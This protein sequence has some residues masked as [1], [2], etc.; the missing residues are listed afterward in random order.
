MKF[1]LCW[2][3]WGTGSWGGWDGERGGGGGDVNLHAHVGWD[4]TYHSWRDNVW[5]RRQY[6][7]YHAADQS[8]IWPNTVS[9]IWAG[10]CYYCMR[11]RVWSSI[12]E[13]VCLCWGGGGGERGE[14]EGERKRERERERER[15]RRGGGGLPYA[16]ILAPLDAVCILSSG[17]VPLA[18]NMNTTLST[19]R[20]INAKSANTNF[21]KELQNNTR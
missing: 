6:H 3:E 9:A 14:R 16:Y 1:Q 5:Y 20:N 19:S 17:S 21:L 7:Y 4:T 8:W 10:V 15:E 13:C 18:E 12:D 2:G 11:L